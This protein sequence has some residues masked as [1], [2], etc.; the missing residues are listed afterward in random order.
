MEE[1]TPAPST[2]MIEQW[3]NDD[4]HVHV[5]INFSQVALLSYSQIKI[6]DC[7]AFQNPNK[8]FSLKYI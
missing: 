3:F 2:T 7:L 6:V 1:G 5:Y 4:M 8:P